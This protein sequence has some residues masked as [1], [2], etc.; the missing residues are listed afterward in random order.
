MVFEGGGKY[1]RYLN[2]QAGS[3]FSMGV[4]KRSIEIQLRRKICG[5]QA[6]A[7]TVNPLLS[8]PRGL[9]ISRPF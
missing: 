9:F 3:S 2:S 5:G 1:S 6:S 7:C 4:K 8:H